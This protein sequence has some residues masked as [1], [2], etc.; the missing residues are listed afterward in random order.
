MYHGI[1][2]D[3][4]V[5]RV[6]HTLWDNL[7]QV[8]RGALLFNLACLPALG[9]WAMG[10]AV[11]ALILAVMTVGP[12]WGAL[13]Q[14]EM[15]LLRDQTAGIPLFW[16]SF[17]HYWVRCTLL[18]LLFVVPLLVLQ[19]TLPVLQ[20]EPPLPSAIWIGLGA[21]F[22]GIAVM[23]TL[24]LYTFPYLVQRNL[25]VY[26]CLRDALILASRYPVNSIGLLALGVLFGF[27]AAYLS[28]AL[29][30]FLPTVYGLFIAANCL[31]V[32][33]REGVQP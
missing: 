28:L 11:P 5:Q 33:D 29:L 18:S 32:L 24:S 31:L 22:L 4:Y 26:A 7:P 12:A 15:Y 19:A 14:Y 16:Q 3:T 30:L 17:R 25:G 2:R 20:W 10:R 1:T 6:V 23:A 13:L 8:M 9:L 21:D 27:G